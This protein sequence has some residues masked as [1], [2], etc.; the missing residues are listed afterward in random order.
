MTT[1]TKNLKLC[2]FHYNIKKPYVKN[3]IKASEHKKMD[4]YRNT[5]LLFE[6][7]IAQNVYFIFR[8]TVKQHLLQLSIKYYV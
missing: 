1:S 5:R 6:M 2:I 7:E 3:T 8:D 4:F